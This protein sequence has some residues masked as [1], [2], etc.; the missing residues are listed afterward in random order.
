MATKEERMG[1][2]QKV[3]LK[4]T[5]E[6]NEGGTDTRKMHFDLYAGCNEDWALVMLHIELVQMEREARDVDKAWMTD[7]ELLKFN[8]SQATVDAILGDKKHIE[9][10]HRAH[11]DESHGATRIVSCE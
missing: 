7:G 5:A 11:P 6:I 3:R 4:I 9:G 10:Q 8:N 2:G 1:R